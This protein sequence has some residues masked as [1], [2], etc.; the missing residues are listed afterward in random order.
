MNNT[1]KKFGGRAKG[2]PNKLTT[3][4]RDKISVLVSGTMDSIDIS[5]F[6]KMEKIKLLQVLCQY[7]IP[8]LQSADYQIGSPADGQSAVTI[9]FVDSAGNNISEI[10]KKLGQKYQLPISIFGL[11]ALIKF[12]FNSK[13]NLE[14][15]TLITQEMLKKG[16]LAANSVYVCTEHNP[17]V[18]EGYERA[19]DLV[20]K[21]IAECEN[22]ASI[23][24]LLETPI[25]NADFQ[26]LS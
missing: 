11:P 23:E 24:K 13:L 6:T 4:M 12:K 22:G 20:F 17:E 16:F 25:C 2:T 15:K 26:R 3:E 19:L 8:K 1:G 10:W 18:L 5:T 21:L 7:I 14:Y 9:Q